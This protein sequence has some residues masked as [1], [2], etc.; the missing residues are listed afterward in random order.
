MA[1]AM[2]KIERDVAT[3][4]WALVAIFTLLLTILVKVY[5]G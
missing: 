5:F 1:P 2:N 4:K 3:S